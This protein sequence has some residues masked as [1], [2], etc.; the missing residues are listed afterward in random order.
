MSYVSF[1][2]GLEAFKPEINKKTIIGVK[3]RQEFTPGK[4]FDGL[5]DEETAAASTVVVWNKYTKEA[6]LL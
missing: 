1:G 5:V 3:C 6:L 4:F 2:L